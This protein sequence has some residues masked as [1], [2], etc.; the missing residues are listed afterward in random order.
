MQQSYGTSHWIGQVDG[1]AIGDVDRQEL[2]GKIRNESVH[3]R[4]G[5]GLFTGRRFDHG[6]AVAMNL[7]RVVARGGVRIFGGEGRF[8][9]RGE[10]A[11]RKITI[12]QDI[13]SAQAGNPIWMEAGQVRDGI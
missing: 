6:Y 9:V 5:E 13:D 10:I 1:S 8:V 11:Q 3:V 4:V 2:I 12:S 7:F